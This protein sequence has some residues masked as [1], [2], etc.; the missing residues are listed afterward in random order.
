M[1]KQAVLAALLLAGFAV[2]ITVASAQ[3]PTGRHAVREGRSSTTS[4]ASR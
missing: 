2:P 4:P 3:D 1:K